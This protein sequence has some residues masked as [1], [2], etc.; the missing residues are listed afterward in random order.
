[1]LNR[2]M[3]LLFRYLTSYRYFPL[4]ANSFVSEIPIWDVHLKIQPLTG[5][6][7]MRMTY[8]MYSVALIYTYDSVQ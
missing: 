1:M 7:A 6:A 4:K 2:C 3:T 8:L 5:Y